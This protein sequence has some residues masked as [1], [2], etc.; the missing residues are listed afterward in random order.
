MNNVVIT[1]RATKDP[2][3][4]FIP[5]SGTAVA[6]ITM[7]VNR[8][9]KKEGQPDA[10]FFNIVAWGKT[11]EAMGNYLKK[12][13]LFSVNGELR[14]N[15]YEDKNGVKHYN[16][17][18]NANQV[19]FLEWGEDTA[20]QAK[21]QQQPQQDQGGLQGFNAMDDDIPFTY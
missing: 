5:S 15:N 18:I 21:P 12:G 3:L 1:G 8:R 19:E 4:K 10:D 14:N 20:K 11:A 16:V 2:E 6:R 7:A 13:R 17:E 9:F